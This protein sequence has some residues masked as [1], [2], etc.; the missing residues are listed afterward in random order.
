[1]GRENPFPRMSLR[2]MRRMLSRWG[3]SWPRA[4]KKG[5]PAVNPEDAVAFVWGISGLAAEGVNPMD[6]IN[7]DESTFLL[8]PQ[9]YYAWARRGSDAVHVWMRENEKQSYPVM[10]AIAMDALKLPLF[11]MGQGQD[12]AIRVRAESGPGASRCRPAHGDGVVNDGDDAATAEVHE[13]SA[14]VRRLEGDSCDHR[15][16]AAH[17][18]VDVRALADELGIR[19]IFILRRLTDILHS[20]DRTVFCALTAEYRALY[21]HEIAPREDKSMTRADLAA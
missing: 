2:A 21:R 17:L 14:G 8:S 10:I 5:R 12:G 19:L 7:G 6:V 15:C 11:T 16:C 1:M 4:V 13:E 9:G 3:W 18:C 20:L